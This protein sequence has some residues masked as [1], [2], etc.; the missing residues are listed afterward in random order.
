MV[1]VT[2]LGSWQRMMAVMAERSRWPLRDA[3]VAAHL[4]R[5]FDY[6]V[7]FLVQGEASAPRKFDPSGE[8]ALRD[9]KRLRK[10][11]LAAG[12]ER[13]VRREAAERFGL[14]GDALVWTPQLPERLFTPRP[15]D[16]TA[17]G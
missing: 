3:T 9:A 8:D 13:G 17:I 1:T 10:E 2:D 15:T 7:D 14:P 16:E 12:G 11:A 4:D 6:V 5:S